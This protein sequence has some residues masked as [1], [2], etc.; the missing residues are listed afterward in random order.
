M[1]NSNKKKNILSLTVSLY[2][3]YKP[4]IVRNPQKSNRR[5]S[6]ARCIAAN[7]LNILIKTGKHF[8]KHIKKSLISQVYTLYLYINFLSFLLLT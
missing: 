7:I 5:F 1:L 2:A 3:A 8:I 4:L 6:T